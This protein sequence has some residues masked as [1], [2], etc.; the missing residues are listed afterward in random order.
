[1]NLAFKADPVGYAGPTQAFLELID[2][3]GIS[4]GTNI[5][6]G[7]YIRIEKPTKDPGVPWGGEVQFALLAEDN[8]GKV[9]IKLYVSDWV[10]KN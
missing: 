2:M 6:A 8:A 1:M 7:L 9:N 5:F 10:D 3:P 4:V